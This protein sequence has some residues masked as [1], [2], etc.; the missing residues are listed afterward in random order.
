MRW[1]FTIIY[2]NATTEIIDEPVGWDAIEWTAKRNMKH[3]G[4]F[5]N[6]STDSFEFVGD[7]FTILNNEYDTYG[8]NAD[9]TFLVEYD[10]DYAGAW[11][12]YYRGKFD[13]NTYVRECGDYCCVKIA[14]S[15]NSCVDVFLSRND[16][17][18]D[19]QSTVDFD[20]KSITPLTDYAVRFNGQLLY[21]Q[22]RAN[23]DEGLT[24]AGTVDDF[25][26]I[27]GQR[28]Y[29]IPVYLPKTVVNDFGDFNMNNFDPDVVFKDE[30]TVDITNDTADNWLTYG[31][32][33]ML[34]ASPAKLPTNQVPYLSI[35]WKAKGTFNIIP[36]YNGTADL[37]LRSY[38]KNWAGDDDFYD[39]GTT[40]LA[41]AVTL[42][43]ATVT[44]IPFDLTFTDT[45]TTPFPPGTSGLYHF[46]YVNTYHP[47]ATTTDSIIFNVQYDSGTD[48]NYYWITGDSYAPPVNVNCFNLQDVMG[49]LP[50]A[51]TGQDC[52]EIVHN[53]AKL[54]F[55]HITNGLRIRRVTDPSLQ[56]I[57]TN[58]QFMFENIQ[59]IFN[60]GWGFTDNET[61][62]MIG[63]L[64]DFYQEDYFLNLGAID[65]VTFTHARNLTYATA[66]V[67][68]NKWEGEELNGL[69][70]VNTKREYSRNIDS[71]NNKLD[72]MSDII[73][74]GYTIEITRRK[75]QSASGTEDW[76]FDNDIFIVN[77]I[78]SEEFNQIMTYNG[79]DS[80]AANIYSPSTRYN[81]K[82]TPARMMMEWM[83][84]TT[85]ANPTYSL[86][87]MQF[88]SGTGNYLA[89]GLMNT[90]YS[91]ETAV[92]SESQTLTNDDFDQQAFV[93]PLWQTIYADF[94]APMSMSQYET[95]KQNPYGLILFECAG[96]GY[97]GW[98]I[99]CN[100]RPNDG[101]ASLKLLLQNLLD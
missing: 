4:M 55:F 30:G 10:C 41:T 79:I 13:F 37:I 99:E 6:I 17:D 15:S 61:K 20:N 68:Y 12:E 89:E 65:K 54:N 49:W 22:D 63:E 44:A 100:H 27:S 36:T 39:L 85:A 91:L 64:S 59:K 75:E 32:S 83:K 87:D 53:A 69:D 67:G 52:L 96:N 82:I 74:G 76:R 11:T 77:I 9:L 95:I 88:R 2:P 21:V 45:I 70:E 78:Y 46:F 58:W 73:A 86:D 60:I 24:W 81:Y 29:N 57:F 98:I 62:L 14:I 90:Q 25:S 92:I 71:N 16:Q 80:G 3:H 35:Y 101:M 38:R 26:G 56:K 33:L 23:N 47:F 72:I 51:Y 93:R 84:V 40:V 18:V 8:A 42:T 66:T 34:F 5:L 28:Y 50:H 7:A 94:E 43:A 97:Q 31:Q 1:R 48:M 19:L